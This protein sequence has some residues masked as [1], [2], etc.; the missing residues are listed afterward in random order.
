MQNNML[1][2]QEGSGWCEQEGPVCSTSQYNWWKLSGPCRHCS[3][4][5]AEDSPPLGSCASTWSLSG[6]HRFLNTQPG[7]LLVQLEAITSHP[8]AVTWGER[9]TTAG[10][11]GISSWITF[12]DEK[13]SCAWLV[14][15]GESLHVLWGKM[16][17]GAPTSTSPSYHPAPFGMTS[18]PWLPY[19][20]CMPLTSWPCGLGRLQGQI[21]GGL[22]P[23]WA[24][25]PRAAPHRGSAPTPH[26]DT[27]S[28]AQHLHFL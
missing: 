11:A 9:W 6:E 8:I 22:G 10:L 21:L 25:C 15:S 18:A 4:Q 3:D 17:C 26:W 7:P 14:Y 19:P 20:C 1:L 27:R 2:L 23:A 24:P 5:P 16:C 12:F 28:I 13:L